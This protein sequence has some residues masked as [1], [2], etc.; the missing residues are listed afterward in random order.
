MDACWSFHATSHGKT[1]CGGIGGTV[2]RTV[3][4]KNLKAKQLQDKKTL[5]NGQ[6]WILNYVFDGIL[7]KGAERSAILQRLE[8][9]LHNY[10]ACV[11]EENWWI[12]LVSELNKEEGDYTIA[13]MQPHGSSGTFYWPGRQD[14]C[15]VPSQHILCVI[16]TPEITS[17]TGHLSKI[18]ATSKKKI[19][20]S[21]NTLKESCKKLYKSVLFLENV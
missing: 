7:L 14:E 17:H 10:V 15:P 4:K 2:K 11:Y 19:D 1:V 18:G 3:A 12:E 9:S 13:F 20:D 5:Q 6:V 8:R 16:E 21:W